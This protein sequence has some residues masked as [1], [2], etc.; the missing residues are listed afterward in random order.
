MHK[1][2]NMPKNLLIFF[3]L[4]FAFAASAQT[5]QQKLERRKAQIQ[6]EILENESQLRDVRTKERSANREIEAQNKKIKLKEQ[7][8]RTT[9]HQVRLLNDDL[10]STQRNINDLK[11][12]LTALKD[13]YAEMIRKSYKSRSMQSRAMFLLSSENF[14]QAYKRAQYMKQYASYRKAQGEEIKKKTD[15]LTAYTAHIESQKKVQ[16]QLL[17]ENEKER[18]DLLKV[19]HEQEVLVGSLKKDQRKLA[20]EIRK[21]QQENR[22][23]DRRI[24]E[25]I[26]RA[27][28]EANRKAAE[29]AAR[30]NPAQAS[31]IRKQAAAAPDKIV[32]TPEGKLISDNFRGNKGKLG[33]PVERG[34]VSL[35]YG[36]GIPHPVHRTLEVNNS[37]L[38]ITTEPGTQAR[39]VFGGE[40][41]SV[42][43]ITPL[44]HAVIILHGDYFTIYQNLINVSVSKGDKVSLKQPLGR[45]RTTGESGRTVLKF[46]IKHNNV[47]ENPQSWLARM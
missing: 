47:Y 24:D 4:L 26:K 37:G 39:A 42:I 15:Q 31:A 7:L 10:Y 17:A 13:D 14:L 44:N 1:V 32:L 22:N 8:I 20:A 16:E 9:E 41:F 18:L 11:K 38:E 43:Q 27:I 3:F 6:K 23:I 29:E 33:W 34:V 25:L 35:G 45:I 28:A 2:H 46:L 40:V 12:E 36:K 30:K 19:K 21:K 5:E